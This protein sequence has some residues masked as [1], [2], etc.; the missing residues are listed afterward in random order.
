ME[1]IINLEKYLQAL[2]ETGE[3]ITRS[4]DGEPKNNNPL[5]EMP[6]PQ[7]RL[8]GFSGVFHSEYFDTKEELQ[9]Y[10]KTHDTIFGNIC[11]IEYLGS[12]AGSKDVIR[13]TCSDGKQFLLTVV[14]E[15]G[16]GIYNHERSVYT[17]NYKWEYNHGNLRP[18]YKAF[19]DRGIVFEDDI[20]AKI[21]ESYEDIIKRCRDKGLFGKI[22][23]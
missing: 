7:M 11:T 1:N 14:D 10:I 12:V 9:E 2:D 13:K 17:G 16:Y 15:D 22:K 21:D 3:L 20:Y 6:T 18:M 19:R 5:K 23:K 8:F 4:I